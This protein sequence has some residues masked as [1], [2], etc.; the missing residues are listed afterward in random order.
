MKQTA[1]E[2]LVQT[3]NKNIE[4]I[5]L[6]KW[7]EIRD[8]IQQALA[9]EKEQMMDGIR[10]KIHIDY[11]G[12]SP[13]LDFTIVFH[14]LPRKGDHIHIIDFYD[15]SLLSDSEYDILTSIIWHIDEVF[16]KKDEYG[17]YAIL[18][19]GEEPFEDEDED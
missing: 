2:W 18:I 1:V 16:W 12:I 11:S 8:I 4:F 13:K 3:L 6:D 9:M 14:T 5:P 10:A 19:V 15:E 7:D 17:V